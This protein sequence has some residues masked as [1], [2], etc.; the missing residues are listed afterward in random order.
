MSDN[1]GDKCLFMFDLDSTLIQMETI[2]EMARLAGKYDQ[3]AVIKFMA[4]NL[5]GDYP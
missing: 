4:T 5:T 2:D 1:W 3:V